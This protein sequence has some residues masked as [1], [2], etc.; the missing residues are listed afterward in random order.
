MKKHLIATTIMAVLCLGATS[1]MNG[2]EEI[3]VDQQLKKES[4]DDVK[5]QKEKLNKIKQA[6]NEDV[7]NGLDK[8]RLAIKSLDEKK[9]EDALKQLK[10]AV[11]SFDIALGVDPKLSLVPV[12]SVVQVRELYSDPE[13]V[14]RQVSLAEDLLEDG[15]VQDARRILMLL[16]SDVTETVTYLPMASYPD[17]IRQAVR[18]LADEKV[19]EAKETLATAMNTLVVADVR[20]VPIPLL[21]ARSLIDEAS[22]ID[23]K[24]KDEVKA[25][26]NQ[27]KQQI[28]IAKLL[29]YE[30]KSSEQYK[31]TRE[32]IEKLETEI[33]GQNKVDKLY[34]DLKTSFAAWIDMIGKQYFPAKSKSS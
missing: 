14:K 32:D 1:V 11:G 29:G 30:L 33:G 18:Q 16:Q 20:V 27:A 19:E 26:L 12:N 13:T 5:E 9:D 15:K 4:A 24:K 31:K 21:A 2:A 6:V 22:K 8:V 3:K 7:R 25:K 17:A 34:K 28:E 23:K 10:E